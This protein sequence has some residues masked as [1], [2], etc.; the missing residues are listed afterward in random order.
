MKSTASCLETRNKGKKKGATK[1][2]KGMPNEYD[3]YAVL[4]VHNHHYEIF[5]VFHPNQIP[6]YQIQ[7]HCTV[8]PPVYTGILAPSSRLQK[9]LYLPVTFWS[10]TCKCRVNVCFI[11]L[12]DNGVSKFSHNF[13]NL[14]FP[15]I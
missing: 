9:S 8:L 13:K 6:L 11:D 7:F 2:R 10:C 12:V 4:H 14:R 1:D 3:P 5:N 15:C